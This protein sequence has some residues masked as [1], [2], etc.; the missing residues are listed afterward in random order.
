MFTGIIEEIGIVKNITS[1]NFSL[2][3]EV[4]ANKILFDTNL[5]D[6]ISTNGVCLTVA[7][8]TK[9]T[10]TADV[11]IQTLNSTNL[12]SLK[13]GDKVNLER[14][15]EL[16]KRFGGHIVS[17]H[18]DGIGKISHKSCLG[19]ATKLTISTTLDILKYIVEKGSITIDGASLT[20]ASVTE[21]D[22]SVFIIP[23]TSEKTTLTNKF[24]GDTVNLENDIFAKYIEK[25][26]NFNKNIKP[27]DTINLSFLSENGFL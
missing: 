7:Q 23:H 13:I 21:K 25:F 24:C 17:G 12:G 26:V 3:L 27:K 15:M 19:V 14:A 18:I 5:G 9:E 2:K 22:F 10:F 8:I 11:M 4:T 16:G 20:V 1:N 6:S